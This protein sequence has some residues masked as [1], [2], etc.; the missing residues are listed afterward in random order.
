MMDE[1]Q[2]IIWEAS[3]LQAKREGRCIACPWLCKED[4]VCVSGTG[5]MFVEAA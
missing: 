2:Q 4:G 3:K 5:C 1:M